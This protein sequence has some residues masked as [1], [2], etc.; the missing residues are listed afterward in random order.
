[1]HT[2]KLSLP[3]LSPV[4]IP[5]W[6]SMLEQ[7]GGPSNEYERV[8]AKWRKEEKDAMVDLPRFTKKFSIAHRLPSF[9][10]VTTP[11]RHS[12][13]YSVVVGRLEGHAQIQPECQSKI[14]IHVMI[15]EQRRL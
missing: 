14:Q 3:I 5:V 1:V 11:A 4:V 15:S 10:R 9:P 2:F 13:Q 7:L 8:G 12:R 6:H